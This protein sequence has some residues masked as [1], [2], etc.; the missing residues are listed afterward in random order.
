[1]HTL[2]TLIGEIERPLSDEEATFLAAVLPDAAENNG[3]APVAQAL[4]DCIQ[5]AVSWPAVILADIRDHPNIWMQVLK[6]AATRALGLDGSWIRERHLP[7]DFPAA[8]LPETRPKCTQ[9][10]AEALEWRFAGVHRTVLYDEGPSGWYARWESLIHPNE[11]ATVLLE[12]DVERSWHWQEQDPGS[13]P[14]IQGTGDAVLL[15]QDPAFP[16]GE[17]EEEEA[18]LT[19]MAD[20]YGWKGVFDAVMHVLRHDEYA[21]NWATAAANL[22]CLQDHWSERRPGSDDVWIGHLYHALDR[23]P[24]LGVNL[25]EH[26]FE[27]L[28][29]SITIKLRGWSYMSDEEPRENSQVQAVMNAIARQES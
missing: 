27:N 20:L 15:V 9:E 23:A 2:L 13:I 22:W 29:W 17:Q 18:G 1:M 16:D 3:P 19:H 28:V 14:F 10:E 7:P 12:Q 4:I 24:T 8:L 21:Q 6:A 5:T 11:S 26:D 25:E